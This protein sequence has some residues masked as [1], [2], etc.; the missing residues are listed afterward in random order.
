[1]EFLVQKLDY[2]LYQLLFVQKD[3]ETSKNVWQKVVN[4]PVFL[5]MAIRVVEKEN[6]ASFLAPTIVFLMLNN[7]SIVSKDIY[8]ALVNTL[9]NNPD[10]TTGIVVDNEVLDYLSLVIRNN[11]NIITER[12]KRVIFNRIQKSHGLYEQLSLVNYNAISSNGYVALNYQNGNFCVSLREDEYKS[13]NNNSHFTII[14][15]PRI[16]DA[17]DF[18]YQILSNPSFSDTEKEYVSRL[19]K[20]DALMLEQLNKPEQANEN[21][22][23]VAI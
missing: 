13:I 17:R 19:I 10:L 7:P 12:W 2:E 1:M 6:G 21:I 22:R 20:M 9:F 23:R 14:N 4:N 5:N 18:R 15:E 11:E 16:K 8:D 3:L